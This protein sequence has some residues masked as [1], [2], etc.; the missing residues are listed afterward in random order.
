MQIGFIGGTGEEGMGLA[1]RFAKAGHVCII[2]SRASEKAAAA[3][4][5]TKEPLVRT[6]EFLAPY[7]RALD[8]HARA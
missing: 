8:G 2:G 3:V 4:A 5:G 6:F 1:Y 7:L